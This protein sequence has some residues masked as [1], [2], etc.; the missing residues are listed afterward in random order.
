MSD[1]DNRCM[2]YYCL[3]QQ[4]RQA[5]SSIRNDHAHS[6]MRNHDDDNRCSKRIVKKVQ[7]SQKSHEDGSTF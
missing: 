7:S 3:P 1:D 4:A 5:F 2:G 6:I